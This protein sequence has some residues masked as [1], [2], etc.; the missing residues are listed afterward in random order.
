[1]SRKDAS[2]G[3][4]QRSQRNTREKTKKGKYYGSSKHVRQQT[5][6]QFLNASLKNT[7]KNTGDG[8]K[9]QKLK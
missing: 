8:T 1:M 3:Y 6:K 9:K 4:S 7:P 2:T 5:E